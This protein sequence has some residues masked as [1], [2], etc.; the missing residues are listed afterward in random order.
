MEGGAYWGVLVGHCY[1]SVSLL[2]V[3]RWWGG[4][5]SSGGHGWVNRCQ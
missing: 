1:C 4:R 5:V 3:V 2:D